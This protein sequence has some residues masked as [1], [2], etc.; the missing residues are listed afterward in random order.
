MKPSHHNTH[1]NG[2]GNCKANCS[3]PHVDWNAFIFQR[4]YLFI[5]FLAA[6]IPFAVVRSYFSHSPAVYEVETSHEE[7]LVQTPENRSTPVP[8]LNNAGDSLVG[9]NSSAISQDDDC[10]LSTGE[11]IPD[12]SGAFYTNATCHAIQEH[13]NCMKHGRPDTGYLHWRWKPMNCE[14]PRFNARRFLELMRGKIL[15]FV[16]D[17]IGRNH[18]QSLVCLLS[19]VEDARDIYNDGTDKFRRWLFPSYN[20]TLAVLWSPFLVKEM[21]KKNRGFCK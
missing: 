10:D 2:A 6:L 16:G 3:H 12:P 13:Q 21:T 17:S 7:T 1:I 15:A 18:M 11:W 8:I 5:W 9:H 4:R 14:L 20:F 19:Q